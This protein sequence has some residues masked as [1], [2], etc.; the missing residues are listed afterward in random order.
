MQT[1]VEEDDEELKRYER[2]SIQNKQN[3]IIDSTQDYNNSDRASNKNKKDSE[4]L[5]FKQSPEINRFSD[6]NETLSNAIEAYQQENEKE[7]NNNEENNNDF[8]NNNIDNKNNQIKNDDENNKN[9]NETEDKENNINIT[10]TIKKQKI[11]EYKII[12][13]GD[14]GVG[15]TS[16]IY[17]YLK[18]KFKNNISEDDINPENNIKL[19]QL[20]ENKKIKLNIWDTA[21]QENKGI[22]FK[23]YYIDVYGALLIFDLTNK[24]S[25]NNL[26]QWLNNLKENCPRD[27]VYCFVGNK[28]DLIEE[29][30]VTYEE[31]KEFIQDYIY[32][33]TS[34]KNGNNVSLAFEQLAYNIIEKQIEE[35]GSSEKVIR[36]VEGRRTTNLRDYNE[37]EIKKK[38]KCC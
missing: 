16:L 13:L 17:R 26:K 22:I 15:K 32:Y 4:D 19:V 5:E 14:F 11:S 37:K 7:L 36:G 30:K 33:E 2:E 24:N 21:G 29:R 27:I 9:I 20:D 18:N 38:K 35:E 34:S 28:S 12:V 10:Q 25:F 23:Q 6:F 31:V 8:E 1:I 3:L